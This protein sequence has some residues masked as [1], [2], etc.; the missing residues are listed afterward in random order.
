MINKVK[1]F[2]HELFYDRKFFDALG[3]IRDFLYAYFRYGIL[4]NCLRIEASTH[5][6]L[7]CPVCPTGTGHSGILGQG[8]LKFRDFKKFVDENSCFKFIE[9]SNY[10]EIFLNPELKEIVKYAYEKGINLT[11]YNGVN[12]NDVKDEV[13]EGIVKY[14]FKA[15]NVAIDGTSEDTYRIYRKK[16]DF[17]KVIENVKK[18]N[19]YKEKYN[20]P[21]PSLTWQ[22]VI[23]GHNEHQ[24]PIAFT[25][26]KEL[27][28]LF[29]PKFNWSP[30]YAP[31]KD[32]EA[33]KK[34]LEQWDKDTS[35]N[36]EFEKSFFKMELPQCSQLW[37]TPQ[38]NWDGKL[39]GCCVQME[40]DFGNVFESGL[41]KCLKNYDYKYMKNMLLG[42]EKDRDDLPCVRCGNYRNP[43]S[44][45]KQM[46][47]FKGIGLFRSIFWYNMYLFSKAHRQFSL[48]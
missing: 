27:N 22:F 3:F 23:F 48:A 28:M 39:I 21:Y 17:N 34:Y 8:Y 2:I 11:A 19:L 18:I 5:C 37:N 16:G 10:G 40:K 43:Q 46:Q 35:A 32:M 12:L 44:L 47:V 1:R 26:A 15:M 36:L 33:V 4:G 42:V 30:T 31:I 38:I 45:H 7:K 14:R 41:R 29:F 25:M 13:L 9:L 6:Q 24:L 20:S